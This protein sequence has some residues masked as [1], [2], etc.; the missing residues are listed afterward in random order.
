MYN[1][2][3]VNIKMARTRL[4][5]LSD[6]SNSS[7]PDLDDY[8][9]LLAAARPDFDYNDSLQRLNQQIFLI[10]E[11]FRDNYLDQLSRST[12]SNRG[13]YDKYV[14]TGGNIDRFDI[15]KLKKTDYLNEAYICAT[16]L[17]Y[18]TYETSEAWISV[19]PNLILESLSCLLN[20][21]RRQV[22]FRDYEAWMRV[23]NG[24][25]I[26]HGHLRYRNHMFELSRIA[27]FYYGRIRD[28]V[29]DEYGYEELLF[30]IHDLHNRV[31]QEFI[32][33]I[34]QSDHFIGI[35]YTLPEI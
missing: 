22:A 24:L 10:D 20:S 28:L 26:N 16:D 32:R 18:R 3:Y 33:N 30:N 17:L 1:N 31:S 29:R 11:E 21:I 13:V 23:N 7:I 5:A 34:S 8:R 19:D 6:L 35:R 9:Q 4:R 27:D 14:R 12:I 2:I 15:M 25:P